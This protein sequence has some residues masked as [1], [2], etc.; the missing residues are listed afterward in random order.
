MCIY[1]N[2]G[3]E[4]SDKDPAGAFLDDFVRSQASMERAAKAML[5]C[6]R[7]AP[8]PKVRR[9]YDR[10]HKRMVRMIRDW[11]RLEQFRERADL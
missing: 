10:T 3:P 6:S 9:Q 8:D 1:C 11:N 2:M 7:L 4:I 5:V